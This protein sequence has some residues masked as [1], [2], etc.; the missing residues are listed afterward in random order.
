MPE[1][2][3]RGVGGGVAA[4]AV[5]ASSSGRALRGRHHQVAQRARAV[6]RRQAQER[7]GALRQRQSHRAGNLWRRHARARLV[8]VP[9]V[10][11]LLVNVGS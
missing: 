9:A 10:V 11:R 1:I 5:T 3:E 7:P 4:K 6:G 8:P 2:R